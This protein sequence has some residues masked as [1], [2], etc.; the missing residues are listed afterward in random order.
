M[1]AIVSTAG[2]FDQYV[3]EYEKG[4]T[5]LQAAKDYLSL[6]ALTLVDISVEA[7]KARGKIAKDDR[8]KQ[9]ARELEIEESIGSVLIAN[10]LIKRDRPTYRVG[11]Y[12][13]ERPL[14][15]FGVL[16]RAGWSNGE[17]GL[18][19]RIARASMP[20][21]RALKASKA[22]IKEAALTLIKAVR[23]N[24]Q[25][26]S[27]AWHTLYSTYGGGVHLAACTSTMQRT[28]AKQLAEEFEDRDE[29]ILARRS[30]T[31]VRDWCDTFLKALPKVRS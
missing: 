6:D 23:D 13:G 7:L 3:V 29:T 27:D 5:A 18:A 2:R 17:A 16:V 9:A 8:A 24:K 22:S 30:V 14:G 26:R 25:A 21:L 11:R 15:V 20:E 4:V 31:Q 12:K 1:Q 28:D 19:L 10:A